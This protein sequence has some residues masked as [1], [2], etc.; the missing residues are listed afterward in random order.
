MIN[1]EVTLSSGVVLRPGDRLEP[2]PTLCD[3]GALLH[4]ITPVTVKL[5]RARR[6]EKGR[7]L[8]CCNH[9][10]PLFSRSLGS[11]PARTLC[12]D[13]LHALYYGPVMRWVTSALWR[14]VLYN[15]WRFGGPLEHVMD[16]GIKH[17][18]AE[19]V[20]WQAQ[21]GIPHVNRIGSITAGMIGA[22]R[23][24]TTQVGGCSSLDSALC[25][26]SLY[27]ARRESR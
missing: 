16:L 9:S 20:F 11:S 19:L 17:V 23:G 25:N 8:D 14:S 3:I 27:S 26:L 22:R 6:D 10:C 18:S 24:A 21:E 7:C 13:S 5:W 2:S 12:I 1:F 4:C 15:P